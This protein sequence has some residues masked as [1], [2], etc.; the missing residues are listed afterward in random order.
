MTNIIKAFE[1]IITEYVSRFDS[2][3]TVSF[4]ITETKCN[5]YMNVDGDVIEIVVSTARIANKLGA[6][7]TVAHELV[8][9]EQVIRGDMEFNNDN[10]HIDWC[11]VHVKFSEIV[12]LMKNNI[13]GYFNLPWEK[14]AYGREEEVAKF[15]INDIMTYEEQT[16]FMS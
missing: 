11:G 15:I 3:Y 6:L 13:A 7:N 14:E 4:N 16:Y 10:G 5:G 1:R 8:H 9:V 12:S 2:K